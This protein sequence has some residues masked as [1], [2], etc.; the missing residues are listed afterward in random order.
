MVAQALKQHTYMP[1]DGADLA[2][3]HSFLDAHEQRNGDVVEP[4]YLLVGTDE[5]DQVELPR[6]V[7]AALKQVVSALQAGRAVT[8]APQTTKLTT[9]QAADLLGV[10]RPTV[11]RLIDIGDLPAEKVG[12]RHRLLLRDVLDYQHERRAQQYEMLAQTSLAF[13]GDE[14]PAEI[15]RQLKEARKAV[16]A[17]RRARRS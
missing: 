15:T 4:R 7:H 16:G 10:S 5:H 3:V 8:I 1:E 9:Q 14:D 13:T 2:T 17:R 12:N 6:E 11:R